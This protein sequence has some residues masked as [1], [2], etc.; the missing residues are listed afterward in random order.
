MTLSPAQLAYRRRKMRLAAR[1]I[2]AAARGR[3]A[4]RRSAAPLTRMIKRVSL[5]NSETKTASIRED[6]INLYHNTTHYQYN[7]LLCQ[8]G[9]TANPGTSIDANRIGNEVIARGIKLRFQFISDPKRP[10]Q[11]IK[12][13]VFKHESTEQPN[14]ANFWVGPAGAGGNQNRMIDFPDTRN[15]TVV[16]TMMIQNQFVQPYQSQILPVHN[17]YR[18]VWIPLNNRKVRY[19]DNNGTLP[20]FTTYSFAVVC[21]DANNTFQ[22]DILNYMSFTSRFYFKDP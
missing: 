2:Q 18:D 9:E 1:R 19:A 4:R 11:N 7:L 6:G 12:L 16:K 13:I 10:N 22:S 20:K 8:Q 5:N 14:D 15:V 17:V 21:Y 3:Q